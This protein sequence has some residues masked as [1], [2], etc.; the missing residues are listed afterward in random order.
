VVLKHPRLLSSNPLLA[1]IL[2][3]LAACASAAVTGD[4]VIDLFVG[5]SNKDSERLWTGSQ[6]PDSTSDRIRLY[7][8]YLRHLPSS[9]LQ[10]LGEAQFTSAGLQII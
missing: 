4:T 8:S 2:N 10:A 6:K 1:I 7:H 5:F 3:I 9:L